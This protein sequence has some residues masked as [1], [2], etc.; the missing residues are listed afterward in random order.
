MKCVAWI[1][2][3]WGHYSFSQFTLLPLDGALLCS[4]Y[5]AAPHRHTL[6]WK[7]CAFGTFNLFQFFGNFSFTQAWLPPISDALLCH[8]HRCVIAKK[9]FIPFGVWH[10]SFPIKYTFFPIKHFLS[11][12]IW[13]LQKSYVEEIIVILFLA[14]HKLT[15]H[16]CWVLTYHST[17]WDTGYSSFY[18]EKLTDDIALPSG[19]FRS[20]HVGACYQFS[21]I[22][23]P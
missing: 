1:G 19:V 3:S 6:I 13:Q 16:F 20:R 2:R 15:F 12:L 7:N 14:I 5:G 8:H 23:K 22:R 10:L 17:D 18:E 4:N 11:F 21:P 9:P